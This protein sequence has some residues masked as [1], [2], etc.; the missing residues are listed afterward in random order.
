MIMVINKNTKYNKH[1]KTKWKDEKNWSGQKF[2]RFKRNMEK[3]IFL[4]A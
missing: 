1:V 4:T 2:K 3:L